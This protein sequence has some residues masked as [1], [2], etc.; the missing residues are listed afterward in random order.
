MMPDELLWADKQPVGNARRQDRLTWKW[1]YEDGLR[2]ARYPVPAVIYEVLWHPFEERGPL[3]DSI[4]IISQRI[5][6]YW[7]HDVWYTVA[8]WDFNFD[9]CMDFHYDVGVYVNERQIT[10]GIVKYNRGV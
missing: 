4:E 8:I 3:H 7:G 5:G 9:R 6:P 10:E 1:C 2:P